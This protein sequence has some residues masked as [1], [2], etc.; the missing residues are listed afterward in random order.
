MESG[1]IAAA[2][3]IGG[4]E[5]DDDEPVWKKRKTFHEA[6]HAEDTTAPM[7]T[8]APAIGGGVVRPPSEQPHGEPASKKL[9]SE[10]CGQSHLRPHEFYCPVCDMCLNGRQQWDDH[11][12]GKKHKNNLLGRKPAKKVPKAE[13]VSQR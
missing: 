4:T 8:T 13:R 6:E 1:S 5:V 11:R 2:S 9:K 12:I 3:A 7:D 10:P